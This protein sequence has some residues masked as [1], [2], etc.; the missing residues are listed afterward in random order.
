M[1]LFFPA[2]PTH[3]PTVI[4]PI[5]TLWATNPSELRGMEHKMEIT[6]K[7]IVYH[8]EQRFHGKAS[9][10]HPQIFNID[11]LAYYRG[12]LPDSSNVL[13]IPVPDDHFI[14]TQFMKRTG[15]HRNGDAAVFNVG[16]AAPSTSPRHMLENDFDSIFS[17]TVYH[18]GHEFCVA[19]H[20]N[21]DYAHVFTDDTYVGYDVDDPLKRLFKIKIEETD[22]VSKSQRALDLSLLFLSLGLVAS[23][24]S[25]IVFTAALF[26]PIGI[27]VTVGLTVV[28]AI[29]LIAY[30]IIVHRNESKERALPLPETMQV[31]LTDSS[32][33]YK[34][35]FKAINI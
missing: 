28:G 4:V 27:G 25:T 6:H 3:T 18:K 29:A 1:T 5:P 20:K 22:F 23:I 9:K 8:V 13:H 26:N 33:N 34:N 14:C 17:T 12:S 35:K 11:G 21:K 10:D 30:N 19:S 32:R 31:V 15:L 24:G 16:Q 7:G 2:A